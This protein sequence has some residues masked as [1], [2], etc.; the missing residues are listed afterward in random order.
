MVLHHTCRQASNWTGAHDN[1]FGFLGHGFLVFGISWFVAKNVEVTRSMI[2]ISPSTGS[3]L[4]RF[5]IF[6]FRARIDVA[7]ADRDGCFVR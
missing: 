5:L 4:L 6:W 3:F 1:N 7:A 2:R